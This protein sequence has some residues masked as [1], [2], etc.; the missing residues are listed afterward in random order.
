MRRRVQ[1]L[2]RFGI[3]ETVRELVVVFNTTCAKPGMC[4]YCHCHGSPWHCVTCAKS[5]M[6]VY[7]HCHDSPWCC[8]TCAKP[9]ICVYCHCH[10]SPWYYV[11]CAK[12]PLCRHCWPHSWH[13]SWPSS[14]CGVTERIPHPWLLL[15]SI[16]L[17]SCSWW[18]SPMIL[19]LLMIHISC[20]TSAIRCS[21]TTIKGS[22]M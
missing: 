20:I 11:T 6:C 8:V 14:Q 13:N 9:W 4:V 5:G 17:W 15:V 19:L 21:I 18:R 2:S 7:C 10:D 3:H 1:T 12:P 16:S 22:T